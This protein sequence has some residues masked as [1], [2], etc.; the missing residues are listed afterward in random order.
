MKSTIQWAIACALV[1]AS[2]CGGGGSSGSSGNQNGQAAG[3]EQHQ[4]TQQSPAQTTTNSSD[5]ANS[6]A[7]SSAPPAEASPAAPPAVSVVASDP[8]PIPDNLHPRVQIVAPRDGALVRT[9]RVEVHLAVTDWPAPQ[10]GRHIHLIL[11]NEPYRRVDDPSRP[12]VLE[13]LAEGTHVLRAFPGWHTHESVKRDGAFAMAVFHVGNRTDAVHLDPHAPLLTYSRPKGDY[14]GDDA[15]HILLDFYVRNV[16]NNQ[17]AANGY[18]VRY[19]ID[20]GTPAEL[21]SWVPYTISNLSDGAHTIALDLIGA[22][23]QPV[24]GPFNHTERTIHVNHAAATT[25]EHSSMAPASGAP[26]H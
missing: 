16:P 14:N 10:D 26:S 18:R 11:D 24:A 15:A 23:G 20:N 22:D 3:G 7:A 8:T 4:D 13:N 6:G 2:A 21:A 1:G 25:N 9:N 5:S 12:V 19:T 17:L